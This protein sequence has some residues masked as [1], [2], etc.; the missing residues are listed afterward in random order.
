MTGVQTTAVRKYG[1]IPI[2]AKW[3][4]R[5]FTLFRLQHLIPSF[6]E[7]KRRCTQCET[8]L[9]RQTFTLYE[10]EDDWWGEDVTDWGCHC[11][12][13]LYDELGYE[14][15]Q[16]YC[17]DLPSWTRY[18]PPRFYSGY[19]IDSRYA[20][21]FSE[22]LCFVEDNPCC[23][24]LWPE[25]SPK[26]AAINNTAYE[27][28]YQLLTCT[29]LKRL[30][31]DK[32]EQRGFLHRDWRAEE[33]AIY[34]VVH[35]LFFSSYEF[36]CRDL[37]NYSTHRFNEADLEIITQQLQL[38][39][40]TLAPLFLELYQNCP[41]GCQSC[42]LTQ[43]NRWLGYL[44]TLPS[45][46]DGQ[47]GEDLVRYVLHQDTLQGPYPRRQIVPVGASNWIEAELLVVQ[48]I[49]LSDQERYSEALVLFSEA[50]Q[51]NPH[52]IDAYL[53]RALCHFE[54]NRLDEALTDYQIAR[55][56]GIAAPFSPDCYQYQWKEGDLLSAPLS[57]SKREPYLWEF[58]KGLVGGIG[59]GSG[60]AISMFCPNLLCCAQGVS[61]GLWA[62]VCSPLEVSREVLHSA[63][64]L[65]EYLS[66]HD[67]DECLECLVP[68]MKEL[69]S[70]WSTFDDQ[71]RGHHLG[72]IME[73]FLTFCSRRS[74]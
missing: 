54:H 43:E 35:S 16:H 57:D 34:F 9:W 19:I 62:F 20:P 6:G 7:R 24:H 73:I 49:R 22:F 68:E 26:A 1:Y 53:E 4:E 38:I 2:V 64:S 59:K 48:G 31:E 60:E 18:E 33:A 67:W 66:S 27:L 11:K 71:T 25:Y 10:S 74:C 65:G 32:N 14:F 46:S 40:E 47:S 52:H 42:Y 44:C 13:V 56:V 45:Q 55:G 5:S 36:I 12:Q 37:E 50:I 39:R 30:V 63:Y 61:N 70:G 17:K 21:L 58:S 8:E 72:Y 28:F 69:R 29:P 23:T 15:R 41:P 3:S 51:K